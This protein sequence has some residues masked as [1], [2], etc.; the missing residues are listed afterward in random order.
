MAEA[1]TRTA[2]PGSSL[3]RKPDQG[4]DR[5]EAFAPPRFGGRFVLLAL[6]SYVAATMLPDSLMEPISSY[7]AGAAAA[8]LGLFGA[9]SSVAGTIV[10]CGAFKADIIP[11]CTS[12]FMVGLFCSFVLAA[13]ASIREKALGLCGGI[14]LLTLVNLVRIALVVAAGARFPA[15]FE[16]IHVYLGQIAMIFAVF[17]VCLVWFGSVTAV[18]SFGALPPFALRFAAWSALLFFPWLHLNRWYVQLGDHLVRAVFSLFDYQLIISYHHELYYQTFNLIGLAALILASG[19][20]TPSEKMRG[21]FTGLFIL[22][23]THALIRVC[24]VMMTTFHMESANRLSLLLNVA[25]NFLLPVILW[26]VIAFRK[27]PAPQ[28][29]TRDRADD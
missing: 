23:A 6:V 12:I 8:I 2:S 27:G 18:P 13:P 5:E 26:L 17:A 20:L 28:G 16:Y 9:K 25:G 22:F 29:S 15:L 4:Q 7:T 21:L 14:P 3:R 1:A 10:T 24:D 19:S 11:E